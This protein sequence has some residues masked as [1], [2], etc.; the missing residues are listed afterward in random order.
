VLPRFLAESLDVNAGTARLSDDEA[1]HLAQ[2]LRLAVGDEVAV[3]DGAGREFRARVARVARDGADLALLDEYPAAPEPAV[4]L[5]LAQAVI[6]GEKMDDLVRDATMMGVT[7]IEPLVTEHTAAHMKEGRAPE[8]WRRIAIASAKQCRR[9]VVPAIGAGTKF[10]DWLARDRAELRVLLVEPSATIEGHPAST[11]GGVAGN[12]PASASLLVGPEGGWS[13]REIEAA[14][15]AG[16]V[17]ITL[18][19]RTLRADAVAVVAIG[20]LQFVW[21]DL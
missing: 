3:F 20:V 1:R 2:V 17:P 7:A 8:R 19:R 16:Y 10:P 4:R 13:V 5:T 15:G 9:A 21:G 11:L 14:A 6:K 12:R 18:G